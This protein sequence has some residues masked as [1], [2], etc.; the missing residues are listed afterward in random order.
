MTTAQPSS[1]IIKAGRDME[2]LFDG[3]FG[4]IE[5]IRQNNTTVEHQDVNATI[6]SISSGLWAPKT[7]RIE[8]SSRIQITAHLPHV[9]RDQIHI[10]VVTRSVSDS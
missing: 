1:A 10:N 2:E 6:S 9:S 4:S 5:S 7:E 3:F 8:D